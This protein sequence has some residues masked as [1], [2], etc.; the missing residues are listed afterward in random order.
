MQVIQ[1]GVGEGEGG[2]AGVVSV[3]KKF[4][5]AAGSLG[6]WDQ[7]CLCRLAAIRLDT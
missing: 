3:A 2:R 5:F 6:L 4:E 1:E 7:G